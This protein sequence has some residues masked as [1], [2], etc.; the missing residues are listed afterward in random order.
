MPMDG[1]TITLPVGVVQA[2]K[3][4]AALD[5]LEGPMSRPRPRTSQAQAP[6]AEQ[7][8]A[9]LGRASV[10]DV[11]EIDDKIAAAER[12][13]DSLRAVRKLLAQAAGMVDPRIEA[14]RKARKMKKTMKVLKKSI[15]PTGDDD[16]EDEPKNDPHEQKLRANAVKI[17]NLLRNVGRPMSLDA[18]STQTLISKFGFACLPQSLKVEGWFHVNSD[19][20]VSFTDK[21]DKFFKAK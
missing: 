5:D 21:G 12:E 16:A 11:K 19:S 20:M 17:G 8:K 13:V 9:L 15:P 14:M 7:L 4:D 6:L 2:V 1:P 3:L 18:I 10:E